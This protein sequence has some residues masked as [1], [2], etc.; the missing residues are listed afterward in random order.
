MQTIAFDTINAFIGLGSIS[1]YMLA[2]FGQV[3]LAM[4]LKMFKKFTG[5]KFIKKHIY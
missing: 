3:A 5:E 1:V 4:I 2:Y